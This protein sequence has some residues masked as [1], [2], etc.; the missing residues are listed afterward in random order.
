MEYW[1]RQEKPNPDLLWNLPEQKTG[2]VTIIGGNASNFSAEIKLTEFLNTL[3]LKTVRLCLPDSLK[4]KLP[5][6]PEIVFAP[7][8]DSGSFKKS[9][10]LAHVTDSADATL[11]SGDLSKNSATAIAIAEVIKASSCPIVLARDSVELVASE[12][13]QLLEQQNLIVTTTFLGLQKILRSIYYP[14]MLLLSMPLT[15]AIEVLHKFTLSYPCTILTFHEG[16]IIIARSGEITTIPIKTTT[17]SPITLMTG[18]L[19]AKITTLCAW[20]PNHL[21]TNVIAAIHWDGTTNF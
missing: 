3:N 18:E 2:L 20:N 16:Q 13:A 6:L 7:A 1:T 14:K 5:P 8:T 10:E 21:L 9:P 4:N 19:A 17:Y 12:M 11:I 15:Q